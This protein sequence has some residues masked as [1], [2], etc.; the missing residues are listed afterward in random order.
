MGFYDNKNNVDMY[1]KMADDYENDIVVKAIMSHV[2]KGKRLLELGMGPGKDLTQL[3][4]EYNCYGSDTSNLFLDLYRDKYNFD[5]LLNLDALTI[6]TE[7]TF[8]CIYSN[9]VLQHLKRDDLKSSID[10]QWILLNEDGIL[11][12]SFWKGTGEEEF[13]GLLFTYYEEE[14][15]KGF[16]N[17]NF[18]I[19]DIVTYREE[20]D[21]DSILLVCRKKINC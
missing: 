16:F 8:D 17:E 9:K 15:L 2:S 18:E 7:E 3:R 4:E 14:E 10:R 20:S 5:Q 13:D 11:V 12:H 1:M 19:L 6:E 21:G